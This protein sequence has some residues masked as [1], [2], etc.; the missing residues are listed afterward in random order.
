[1]V[2]FFFSIILFLSKL[3][4]A[5]NYEAE[6]Q[7][8]VKSYRVTAENP[9]SF[10][11]IIDVDDDPAKSVDISSEVS[12]ASGVQVNK[13]GGMDSFSTVMIRGASSN[14]V[15]IYLNGVRLNSSLMSTFNLGLIPDDIVSRVEIYKGF[16]PLRL[17]LSNLGGSVNIILKRQMEDSSGIKLS[18]GSFNTVETAIYTTDLRDDSGYLISFFGR[19]T[20]GDFEYINR[21]GTFEN[22]EDDRLVKRENNQRIEY[23][24]LFTLSSRLSDKLRANILLTPFFSEGGVPGIENI[25]TENTSFNNLMN[26]F[27]LDVRLAGYGVFKEVSLGYSN[28]YY[29]TEFDDSY[30]ELNMLTPDKTDTAGIR[31]TFFIT[32]TLRFSRNL[33]NIRLAYLDESADKVSLIHPNN[34]FNGERGESSVEMEGNIELLKDRLYLIPSAGLRFIDDEV[35]YS[36]AYLMK[37]DERIDNTDEIYNM[38]IGGVLKISDDLIFKSNYSMVKRYPDMYELFGDGLYISPNPMLLPEEGRLFDAGVEFCISELFLSYSVYKSNYN[39]LIQFWQNSQRTIRAD[40]IAKAEIYGSELTI[41]PF[42]NKN[43]LSS[44]SYTHQ[45]PINKSEIPSF[46]DKI[47]PFR[48]TD[49][50]YLKMGFVFFNTKLLYEYSYTSQNFFDAANLLPYNGTP[51]RSIHSISLNY[52]ERR[53][54][55]VFGFYAKNILNNRTED[56]AG[57]PLPGRIFFAGISKTFKPKK[58]VE[59]EKD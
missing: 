25:Q 24:L 16:S 40:N 6:F 50:L 26:V 36:S 53:Y 34:K 4:L 42:L 37:K 22:K 43:I 48:Y 32:S 46:K 9:S 54:D 58:E 19:R 51:L 47:L 57:Y 55:L 28:L 44:L 56:I 52:Y 8:E 20:D 49:S 3:A 38:R 35:R 17:G 41:K 15:D 5:E 59:D 21:N 11:E 45:E 12:S 10:I 33:L 7:T 1:M 14:S 31:H 29:R 30:G 18:Y 27:S 13:S 39:N 23:A 2:R